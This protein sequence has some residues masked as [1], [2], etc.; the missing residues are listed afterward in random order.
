MA[1]RDS[2]RQSTG[3]SIRKRCSGKEEANT[4][5]K[6][7]PQVK[8]RK[9]VRN[10]RSITGLKKTHEE[11]QSHFA[12][13]GVRARLGAGDE[14]PAEDAP[15][16]PDVRRDE[17]PHQRLEFEQDVADVEDCEQPFVAVGSE[18]EVGGHAGN[19]GVADVG[20]VEEGEEV[21]FW[22]AI[23]GRRSKGGDCTEDE[24]ERDDV[25]V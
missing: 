19:A 1:G 24:H 21:W 15:G 7:M 25:P 9:K 13:P 12:G 2:V 23:V 10:T 3:E 4:Q 8:E 22:L 6:L 20:A 11:A 18:F 14:A 16:A 5:T 17:L